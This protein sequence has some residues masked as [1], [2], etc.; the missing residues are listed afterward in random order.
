MSEIVVGVIV[1]VFLACVYIG[2]TEYL[3]EKRDEE[4]GEEGDE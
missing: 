1:A 2:V 3:A 4:L